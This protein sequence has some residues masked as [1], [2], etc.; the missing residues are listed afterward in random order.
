MRM[1]IWTF[2]WRV[3]RRSEFYRNNGTPKIPQ[4]DLVS[5]EFDGIDVGRRSVP[6]F[7]DLDGDGDQD[8][9]LGREADGVALYMNEGRQRS[10]Y[11][12]N[13]VHFLLHSPSSQ[14]LRL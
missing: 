7:A 12:L 2:Y 10:P 8:L 4:F 1:E 11:L 5:D 3:L 9:I 13:R 14:S 6:R